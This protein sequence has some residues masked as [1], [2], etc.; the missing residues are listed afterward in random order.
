MTGLK[1]NAD[2]NAAIRMDFQKFPSR[3]T[4]PDGPRDHSLRSLSIRFREPGAP[5]AF[6]PA[7][8]SLFQQML[9]SSLQII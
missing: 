9:F 2:R 5:E 3:L 4:N 1:T 8:V 6:L 7:P